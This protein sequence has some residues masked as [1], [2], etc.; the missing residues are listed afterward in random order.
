MV[1]P[2]DVLQT[3]NSVIARTKVWNTPY[4]LAGMR[5]KY[6]LLKCV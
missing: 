5:L 6:K 4:A 1:N 2:S 3:N